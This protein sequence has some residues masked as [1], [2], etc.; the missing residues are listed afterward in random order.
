MRAILLIAGNFI[1]EQRWVVLAMAVWPFIVVALVRYDRDPREDFLFALSQL[2]GYAVFLAF[3]LASSAIH[4]E[5]K[6]RRILG[7]LSKAVERGDYLAGLAIGILGC[8]VIYSA[9]MALPG[10]WLMQAM[11][12]PAVGFLLGLGLLIVAALL[13]ATMVLLF[14]TFMPP[15]FAV[16]AATATLAAP[17]LLDKVW[18]IG[19]GQW[20]PVYPLLVAAVKGIE[21]LATVVEAWPMAALAVG[22][23]V[24]LWWVAS[25]IFE[26]RD[27]AVAIE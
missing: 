15:I 11:K 20:L 2:Y 7:V 16:A 19:G 13:V 25:M 12:V 22:E 3:L 4:N 6:T 24:V 21:D 26:R 1:R 17:V 10:L 8:V 23:A 14:A 27:I 18:G 9:V 5:R